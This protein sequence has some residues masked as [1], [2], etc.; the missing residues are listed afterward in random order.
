MPTEIFERCAKNARSSSSPGSIGETHH[1]VFVA[2]PGREAHAQGL[3]AISC[4]IKRLAID[5]D[6]LPPFQATNPDMNGDDQSPS[7]HEGGGRIT[8]GCARW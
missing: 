5:A 1:F 6:K 2:L 4:S 7:P 8:A 3:T